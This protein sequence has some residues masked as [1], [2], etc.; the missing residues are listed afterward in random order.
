MPENGQPRRSNASW[1]ES[2]PEGLGGHD[3]VGARAGLPAADP[4]LARAGRRGRDHRPRLRADTAASRAARARSNRDRP[5]RRTVATRQGTLAHLAPPRTA[6]VGTAARVRHRARTRI[7]RADDDGAPTRSPECDDARLRVRDA[8]TPARHASGD[9]GGRAG[10]DPRRPA[11]ASGRATTE[12][13]ALPRAEGG[14][15]PLRLR[16]G[17]DGARDSG[18][19]PRPCARRPSAP[20]GRLALPPAFESTLP[21]DARLPGQARRCELRRDPTHRR[22][23]GVRARTRSA[24]RDRPRPRRGR[25]E[26]DLAR[27]RRGLCGRDDES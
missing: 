12:A 24:F 7:A 15:L 22:A 10:V 2:P 21:A 13:A 9:E 14:V 27:R 25:T 6:Q 4:A 17:P 18:C 3:G 5:P 8:A 23:T 26:P 1:L 19:R 16:A 20:A 11:R